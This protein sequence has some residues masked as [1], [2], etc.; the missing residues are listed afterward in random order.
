MECSKNCAGL[1]GD[2]RSSPGGDGCRYLQCPVEAATA[3]FLISCWV[4]DSS[5]QR[6]STARAE[7]LREKPESTAQPCP[8]LAG[9]APGYPRGWSTG[10]LWTRPESLSES[11]SVV[12]N[13]A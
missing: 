8:P 12:T 3:G 7:E 1:S 4:L 11:H 13:G 5:W 2:S 6:A 10:L 9:T